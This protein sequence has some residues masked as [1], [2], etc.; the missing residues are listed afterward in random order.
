MFLFMDEEFT[1]LHKDTT[2]ISLGIVSEDGKRFYAE[3][4]DYDEMQ[5]NQWINDNVINN[6]L[7]Y[8]IP[9]SRNVDE[10]LRFM[11]KEGYVFSN[12][13]EIPGPNSLLAY[14]YKKGTKEYMQVVGNKFWIRNH[15]IDWISQFDFIQFV[16]DVCHYDFVLLIDLLTNGGTALDLSDNISPVCHGLNMDIARHY[17]I[18]EREAFDKNR[19]EI[20]MELCG[21]EVEGKKHNA[22]Y[23][24]EVIKA[25]F[26]EIG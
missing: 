14:M 8:P 13:P 21:Y 3:F 18:S 10:R 22:L 9:Y 15:L 7:L 4:T 25:I 2:L 12:I 20:V 5:C 24:A 17:G 6:L 23:D 1:G 19:E 16:S 26:E 11:E